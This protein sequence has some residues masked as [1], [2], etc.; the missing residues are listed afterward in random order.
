VLNLD[1]EPSSAALADIS[2]NDAVQQVQVVK[3]PPAGAPL[4]WAVCR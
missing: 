1:N 4:P 2:K 3:L